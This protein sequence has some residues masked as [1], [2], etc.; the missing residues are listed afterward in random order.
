MA[1]WHFISLFILFCGLVIF[2]SGAEN[3]VF[4]SNEKKKS[5]RIIR[6]KLKRDFNRLDFE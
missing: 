2:Y 5:R 3:T 4:S 1:N 6:R